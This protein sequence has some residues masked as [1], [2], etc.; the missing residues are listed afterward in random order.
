[1]RRG[2]D[3]GSCGSEG[4]G[5]MTPA[6]NQTASRL[7]SPRRTAVALCHRLASR[8]S[9]RLGRRA[10]LGSPK[11]GDSSQNVASDGDIS[12]SEGL[13]LLTRVAGRLP[14]L[15]PRRGFPSCNSAL[16]QTAATAHSWQTGQGIEGAAEARQERA[17]PPL[18]TASV[19]HVEVRDE[20]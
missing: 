14:R 2:A 3:H 1:M 5:D 19:R 9:A 6:S 20:G 10:L 11:G 16:E 13:A 15:L 4:A 17:A 8:T 18:L 12:G 7:H